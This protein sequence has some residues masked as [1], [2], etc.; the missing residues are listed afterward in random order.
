MK[1]RSILFLCVMAVSCNVSWAL[2]LHQKYEMY[3]VSR[4]KSSWRQG[5]VPPHAEIERQKKLFGYD[6]SIMHVRETSPSIAKDKG[7][8]IK[9]FMHGVAENRNQA[10][11]QAHYG[12]LPGNFVSF[13]LPDRVTLFP[14]F[15]NRFYKCCFGQLK[16]LLPALYVMNYA[17]KVLNVDAL[18]LVGFSRGG[19]TLVNALHVLT[20]TSGKYDTHFEHIGFS[21]KDR[22]DLINAIN[23]GSIVL[24]ASIIDVRD[25]DEAYRGLISMLCKNYKAQGLQ[26]IVSAHSI[27]GI[28]CPVLIHFQ[29]N[30]RRVLNVKEADFYAAFCKRNPEHTFLHMGND[31]GHDKM[32]VS[33]SYALNHFYKNIGAAFDSIKDMNYCEKKEHYQLIGETLRQPSCESVAEEIKSYHAWCDTQE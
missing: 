16:E 23:K 20:D 1:K 11:V 21:Q 10:I 27:Q 14:P 18:D 4:Y 3:I 13:N 30:D 5:H 9:I 32:P 29:H 6:L 25:I 15:Y 7:S 24:R 12:L 28:T 2:T 8:R 17:R 26:P 22:L 31:G 33:F 19:A